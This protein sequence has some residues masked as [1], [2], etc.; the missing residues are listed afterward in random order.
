MTSRG[1]ARLDRR[2]FLIALGAVPVATALVG[3]SKESAPKAQLHGPDLSGVDEA[4]RIQ[5][6]LYRHMNG[7]WLKEYQLPPDKTSFGTFDEVGDRVL[8]QLRA[9]IDGIKDPK[10]G[11]TEQQIRDLYDARLDLDTIEKLGLSPLQGMFDQID[12]AATK[13]DLAKVMGA[14]P[15]A[16]LMGLSITVDRKDS[17]AYLPQVSQSGIGMS[18]Q[19]YRKPEFAEY[20]SAYRTLLERLSAGAGFPDPQGMAQRV[21]DLET[22][23]AAG[24]WDNVRTRDTDATYNLESWNGLVSLAPTFDWDPWLAGSTNRPKELFEKIVV[25]QPSFVT[26]AGQ[27]WTEVDIAIWRDYLK[28]SLLRKY[29]KYLKKDLSDANFDY[30]KATSGIQQRPELWKSAVGVVDGNLGEPLGK[31]YV[32]KYFPPE[33]KDR[34]KELVDNLM[35]AYRENFRNSTWMSPQTRDAAI[36]K[37]DKITTKIGYPDKW[38]DYSKVKV[39]RGKLVESILA[40]EAF[41]SQRAMDRLGKPVDKTEWG[42]SPQTVN[43]YYEAT[44]NSINFP[45]AILQAPFFDKD[46]ESAV[47]YGAIGAII[48]HEIGHGFDDQGSKY[49]GEGNRRDWWTTQDREA[50]DAKTKQVIAQYNALVPEGLDPGQHV[51][52]ELTVGE[53]L[54]DLRGL[55]IALAAFRIEEKKNGRDNLD[56]TPMFQAWGRNWREKQTEQNLEQQVAN[57]PHSPNEF[58]CNQVVRN[59]PEFY[60]TFGVKD[61]DKL[62]LP[63]DQRVSL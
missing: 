39:S 29:A 56:Y 38:V 53:N 2:S 6:D 52:G 7:K 15:L 28:L 10:D 13:P 60:S 44:S 42:M 35:A 47:N 41:E 22:R 8:D 63:E 57:D 12:K 23:I 5:D 19:Y 16:G 59:L 11:T 30:Q 24:F 9:V 45:A 1:R 27:L 55:Q 20:L 33:A 34:A 40:I 3:C 48:G 32:E 14:L 43:A 49:D 51:N 4:V 36:A 17:N 58:R 61:T 37:L 25:G 62:F 31:L 18:E 26:A 54:A 50:F 21:L 46:A